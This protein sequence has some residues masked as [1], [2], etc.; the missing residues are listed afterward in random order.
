MSFLEEILGIILT[1]YRSYLNL[2]KIVPV[3]FVP[4]I[5]FL[6]LNLAVGVEHV[7]GDMFVSVQK[8]YAIFMKVNFCILF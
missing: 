6:W 2:V 4:L 7:G 8:A 5:I 1:N 3:E